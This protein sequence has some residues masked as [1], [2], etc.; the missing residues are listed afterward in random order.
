MNDARYQELIET[1]WR[2][3]LTPGEKRELTER[4]ARNPGLREN[5]L[6]E[7]ALNRALRGLA[8]APVSSNFVELVAR[9]A[10]AGAGRG[11]GARRSWAGRVWWPRLGYSLAAATMMGLVSLHEYR[12]YAR[13]QMARS[14]E[15]LTTVAAVPKIEWLESFDAIHALQRAPEV[16]TELLALLQ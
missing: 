15:T 12:A 8:N 4:Q 7:E 1:S 6:E 5:W 9:A 3:P 11:E 16:D 10:A 13:L 14:V 2:R